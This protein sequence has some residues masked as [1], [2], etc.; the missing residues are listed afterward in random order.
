MEEVVLQLPW[1]MYQGHDYNQAGGQD[2]AHMK[3]N[4]TYAEHHY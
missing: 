2:V 3:Y 1:K 4:K